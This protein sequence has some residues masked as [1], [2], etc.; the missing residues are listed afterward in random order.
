MKLL[1]D[2]PHFLSVANQI[3]IAGQNR[4]LILPQV[5]ALPCRGWRYAKQ[6]HVLLSNFEE[7]GTMFGLELSEGSGGEA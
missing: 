7:R 6:T 1:S 4:N 2:W 5:V 3:D